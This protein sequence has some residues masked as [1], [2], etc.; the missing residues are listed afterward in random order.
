MSQQTHTY[1]RGVIGL[2]TVFIVFIVIAVVGIFAYLLFFATP[3]RIEPILP[4]NLR[5]TNDISRV[6]FVDLVEV[7]NSE[8][9]KSL[10]LFGS[11]P[12]VGSVGR[13]NPFVD[14]RTS[15]GQ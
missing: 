7:V 8:S 3:P 5:A 10:E 11:I 4:A 14:Y 12:G 1:E 6:Q 15:N 9:F 13:A 2:F